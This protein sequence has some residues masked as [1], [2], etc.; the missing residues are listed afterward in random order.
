MISSNT[1]LILSI[2]QI[3]CAKILNILLYHNDITFREI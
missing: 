1:E 2:E 3:D